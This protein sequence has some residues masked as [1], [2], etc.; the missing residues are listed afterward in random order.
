MSWKPFK[1]KSKYKN[2]KVEYNGIKFDSIKEKNRFIQLMLLGEQGLITDLILQ[3]KFE[4]QPKF[5][6]EGKTHRA[7]SY[8]GDFQYTMD[9]KVIVEDVKASKYFTTDVYKLKKKLLLFKYPD[10]NFREIFKV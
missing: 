10:I 1:K 8:V 4:L 3:P 6:H 9:G 5:K 7:I 2:T